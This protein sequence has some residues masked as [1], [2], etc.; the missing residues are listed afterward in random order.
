M[1]KATEMGAAIK[2]SPGKKF[3]ERSWLIGITYKHV[4]VT[5]IAMGTSNELYNPFKSRKLW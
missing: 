5:S 3:Q 1:N 2:F 4:Y